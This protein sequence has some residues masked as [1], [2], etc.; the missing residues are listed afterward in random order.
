MIHSKLS[1][2]TVS[3]FRDP[4]ERQISAGH[5]A[6]LQVVPQHYR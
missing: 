2:E 3:K 6:M 5:A 4:N 1:L